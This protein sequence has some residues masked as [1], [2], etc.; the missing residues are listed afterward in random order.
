MIKELILSALI[1]FIPLKSDSNINI[2][3]VD[4]LNTNLVNSPIANDVNNL[5]NDFLLYDFSYSENKYHLEFVANYS[6]F[7]FS[8]IKLRFQ[9]NSWNVS[10]TLSY[11]DFII[12]NENDLTYISYDWVRSDFKEDIVLTT[13]INFLSGSSEYIFNISYLSDEYSF[14]YNIPELIVSKFQITGNTYNVEL[15]YRSFFPFVFEL[16]FITF[17]SSTTTN[18]RVNPNSGYTFSTNHSVSTIS[19]S[20]VSLPFRS[21]YLSFLLYY[22][23]GNGSISSENFNTDNSGNLILNPTYTTI[24]VNLSESI[25]SQFSSLYLSTDLFVFNEEFDSKINLLTSDSISIPNYLIDTFNE[26]APCRFWLTGVYKEEFQ[27]IQQLKIDL[28]SLLV[29]NGYT[30]SF[31][32]NYISSDL[33]NFDCSINIDSLITPNDYTFSTK[34][35]NY[36]DFTINSLNISMY[37]PS[38][39]E[40]IDLVPL[41]LT[42]ITL[43]FTF[44]SNAFN[45]TLWPNTPYAINIGDILL[46]IV[47]MLMIISI[48]KIIMSMKG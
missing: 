23:N 47:V 8:N 11:N 17:P 6:S 42:I 15:N 46:F 34:M 9:T 22:S 29:F 10:T 37:I 4:S 14:S 48:I 45:L 28:N 20:F 33:K 19:F 7:S 30:Q 21:S 26:N 41:L 35:S 5:N 12:S 40:V 27:N 36:F 31:I 43:P 25:K 13:T 18:Y 1:S 16:G 24:N 32:S 3:Y 2:S 44:F 38:T 39:Q